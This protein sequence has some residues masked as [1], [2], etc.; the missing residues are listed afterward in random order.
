MLSLTGYAFTELMFTEHMAVTIHGRQVQAVANIESGVELIRAVLAMPPEQRAE[1]GGVFDNPDQFRGVIVNVDEEA[2]NPCRFSVLSTKVVDGMPAGIRYGLTDESSK[3]NLATVLAWETAVPGN[4]R[5]ALMALPGMS[6]E[7]ADHILDW[8][9]PDVEPR[10]Y[11]GEVSDYMALDTPY[12]P[13]NALPRRLEELLLVAGVSRHELLGTDRNYNGRLDPY[14]QSE[15]PSGGSG[16]IG[17]VRSV[18][19]QELLTLVSAESNLAP[20][21]EPKLNLNSASIELITLRLPLV[22]ANEF[23]KF[24]E[25]Y[26]KY[27][28]ME[29]EPAR[30]SESLDVSVGNRAATEKTSPGEIRSVFDLVD[31]TVGSPAGAGESAATFPSPIKSTPESLDEWLVVLDAWTTTRDTASISGRVNANEAPAPVLRAVP[32]LDESVAEAIVSRR[33]NS[34]GEQ[35]P[36]LGWLLTEGIVD[37]PKLRVLAPNLTAS[38]DV[39]SFQVVGYFDEH[40]PVARRLITLDATSDPPAVVLWSDLGNTPMGFSP[41]EL[42][43]GE[44]SLRR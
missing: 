37:L 26:R 22:N 19:W 4:G 36:H 28:P 33:G 29:T 1:F 11:G 2:S 21:G 8:I 9:D 44:G 18:P 14:E 24:V 34:S 16:A 6:E 10:E 39:C 23:A 31:A 25:A 43:V 7:T 12:E 41:D 30:P 3:L 5:R 15:Q 32:D 42:G 38:G 17:S 35:P 27:G 13:C 40:G 20:D